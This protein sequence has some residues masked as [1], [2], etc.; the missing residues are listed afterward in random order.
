VEITSDYVYSSIFGKLHFFLENTKY[1]VWQ[2]RGSVEKDS[3]VYEGLRQQGIPGNMPRSE[4]ENTGSKVGSTESDAGSTGS[5][6][7]S[8][9]SEAGS[10]GS[11]ES[12][13]R[14]SVPKEYC[15]TRKLI[16]KHKLRFCVL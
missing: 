11:L 2:S 14:R 8:I 13:K 3:S 12:K 9:G 5:K 15:Y 1:S 4:T 6:A 7:G 10:S 16:W